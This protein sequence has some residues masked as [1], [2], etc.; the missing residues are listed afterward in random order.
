MGRLDGFSYRDV[1][2]RLNPFGFNFT[3]GL[4][5]AMKFGIL[6]QQTAIPQSSITQVICLREP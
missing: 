3:D 4:P 5:G 6:D 1:I 2:K